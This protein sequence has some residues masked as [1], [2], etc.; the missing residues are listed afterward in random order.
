MQHI[1]YQKIVDYYK[2]LHFTTLFRP[3]SFPSFPANLFPVFGTLTMMITNFH[4]S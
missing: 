4:F 2:L 3:P 1:D